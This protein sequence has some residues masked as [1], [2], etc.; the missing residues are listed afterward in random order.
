[1]LHVR[2]A[3]HDNFQRNRH[4]LLNLFGRAAGPLGDDG[5]VIIGYIR[6]GFDGQIVERNGAP[7][8]QQNGPCG[9]EKTIVESEV[10]ESANHVLSEFGSGRVE[11]R[12]FI[13]RNERESAHEAGGREAKTN[14][15]VFCNI[16]Y[17]S[18]T[19][20]GTIVAC[21]RRGDRDGS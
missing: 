1:M 21:S 13:P 2:N 8:E 11:G 15:D 9:D 20:I 7:N 18:R 10:Y 5:D 16:R 14:R 17:D 3:R 19:T 4:L 6:I 12:R